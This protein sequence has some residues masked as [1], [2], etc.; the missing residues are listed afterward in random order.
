MA[1]ATLLTRPRRAAQ[2]S[3]DLASDPEVLLV[4]RAADLDVAL[5]AH[6]VEVVTVRD[7][8][9]AVL[10]LATVVFRVVVVEAEID[11]HDGVTF[12]TTPRG[13]RWDG[14][15]FVVLPKPGSDLVICRGGADPVTRPTR[16]DRDVIPAIVAL[17]REP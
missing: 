1:D 8:A 6:G 15:R 9:A 14:M 16:G 10:V 5:T 12:A 11:G 2:I 17:L 4:G 3:R 13:A 7:H